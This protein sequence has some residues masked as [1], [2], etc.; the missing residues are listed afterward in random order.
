MRIWPIW[1]KEGFNDSHLHPQIRTYLDP[2]ETFPRFWLL[3]LPT[4]PSIATMVGPLAIKNRLQVNWGWEEALRTT[5]FISV[6]LQSS[7]VYHSDSFPDSKAG[8]FGSPLNV[9]DPL[10]KV[11]QS[12][13]YFVF[14][15]FALA[16]SSSEV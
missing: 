7:E 11:L 4:P 8:F 5:D 10:P 13:I 6:T 3:K 16:M 9:D 2:C 15:W 14:T 12:T 1:F